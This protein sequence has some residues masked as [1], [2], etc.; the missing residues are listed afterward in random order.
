MWNNI[1]LDNP[2]L[3]PD[4]RADGSWGMLCGIPVQCAPQVARMITS[5]IHDSPEYQE[6]LV[7]EARLQLA[8]G[9]G[10]GKNT[11]IDGQVLAFDALA[12]HFADARRALLVYARNVID[13]VMAGEHADYMT[14]T[15]EAHA[16]ALVKFNEEHRPG[17]RVMDAV[18]KER[19]Q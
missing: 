2:F 17:V 16:K 15:K 18:D 6:M 5:R 7:A 12:T 4:L 8:T 9:T 10:S 11:L 14:R 13:E 1:D 19:P 3:H